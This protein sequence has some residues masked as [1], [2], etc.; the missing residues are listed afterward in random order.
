VRAEVAM[1]YSKISVCLFVAVSLV[2]AW[3]AEDPS[4]VRSFQRGDADSSGTVEL[5]DVIFTL[6][7]LFLGEDPPSCMDAAD[8]NDDGTVDLSDGVFTLLFLFVGGASIPDPGSEACGLDPTEDPLGCGGYSPCSCGGFVGRPCRE[9]YFCE[10]P[11]GM[12]DA[13]DMLGYCLPIPKVCPLFFKPVCG[14]DGITYGND[15][16]RMMAGVWKAHD[17]PCETAC[18]G[19]MGARC[20]EGQFCEFEPG[21]CGEADLQGVCTDVPVLCTDEYAP[22]CG[23]DKVTYGNDCQRRAAGVSKLHDGECEGPPPIEDRAE[24]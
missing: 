15:C 8:S 22:V 17:G 1:R 10:I 2:R 11:A 6:G 4:T 13:A 9:G 7:S 19:I 14:C 5:T 18:G 16:E 12:C 24:E 20:P 3:G 23:C 21:T